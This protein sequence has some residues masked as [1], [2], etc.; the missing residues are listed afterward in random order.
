[1][2]V[3]TV[4]AVFSLL[5]VVS[6]GDDG[7]RATTVF[8]PAVPT[9]PNSGAS[10]A[11]SPVPG[12]TLQPSPSASAEKPASP[13]PSDPAR[14]ATVEL[15]SPENGERLPEDRDFEVEGTVRDLG[16][17][18]LRIFIYA[19]KRQRFYLAD[20]G[21]DEV[22][23]DGDWTIRSAGIGSDWGHEGDSYLVL[24]VRADDSCKRRLDDL[25]L[26]DDHYPSFSGL[27]GGCQIRAQTRVVEE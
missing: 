6:V 2:G 4:L 19:Q 20:Y 16:D 15:R 10:P 17:D 7:P 18:D 23:D 21:R 22:E 26:G 1:M 13:T 9:S 25:D 27:P 3:A 11:D 8:P 5:W 14:V 12:N 24:A